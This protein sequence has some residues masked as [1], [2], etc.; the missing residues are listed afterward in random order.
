MSQSSSYEDLINEAEKPVSDRKILYDIHGKTK[1]IR[2]YHKTEEE[3]KRYWSLRKTM[4]SYLNPLDRNGAYRAQ[5]QAL[6]EMGLNKWHS[7]AFIKSNLPIVFDSI[8]PGMWSKFVHKAPRRDAR[9]PKNLKGRIIQ[10]Y[11]LL[12]RLTGTHPYG[13]KLRQA[14]SCIDIKYVPLDTDVEDYEGPVRNIVGTYHFRLSTGF[15]DEGAIFPIN[16][17]K[18][19]RRG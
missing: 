1:R 12:Q 10:N 13:W 19:K 15:E 2:K 3:L 14:L 18:G 11:E 6:I 5:V 17:Y 7:Y 9:D 4:G 16:N 8:T